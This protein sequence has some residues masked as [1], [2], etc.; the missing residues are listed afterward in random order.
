MQSGQDWSS[1]DNQCCY[2]HSRRDIKSEA[3]YQVSAWWLGGEGI[4]AETVGRCQ[5]SLRLDGVPG[6]DQGME[7]EFEEGT[8]TPSCHP[9]PT[10]LL[11]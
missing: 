3:L 4:A 11:D 5:G 1:G 9:D 7:A 10:L 6:C 8:R 2:V